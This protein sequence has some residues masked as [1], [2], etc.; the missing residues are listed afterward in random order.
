MGPTKRVNTSVARLPHMN[1]LLR[2]QCGRRVPMNAW[3]LL[4]VA[5][6]LIQ[7]GTAK[8]QDTFAVIGFGSTSCGSWTA[9]RRALN[10]A[11]A[12]GYE[13]WVL[14]FVAS[15]PEDVALGSFVTSR[16]TARMDPLK[17]TDAQVVWG[18]IDN[19]CASHPLE[20]V[21]RAAAAFVETAV[22]TR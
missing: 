17:N 9:A 1:F 6:I 18:W 3:R 21:K 5:L 11:T 8:A 22:A 2:E 16:R 12:V 19:Y 14:G 20:T 15:V 4:P 13:Q 10:A 7:I